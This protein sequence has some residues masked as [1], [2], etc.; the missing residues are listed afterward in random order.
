MTYIKWQ[1]RWCT[2]YMLLLCMNGWRR[3]HLCYLLICY[4]K[5]HKKVKPVL[6]KHAFSWSKC[7]SSVLGLNF[8]SH[9][10]SVLHNNDKKMM[11]NLPLSFWCK[12]IF[13]SISF[14]LFRPAKTGFSSLLK[15]FNNLVQ[16]ASHN[17]YGYVVCV[18]V[19]VLL[20]FKKKKDA[21][22]YLSNESVTISNVWLNQTA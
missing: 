11:L 20:F 18:F 3:A 19:F 8:Q 9:M 12:E 16:F 21:C 10:L 14:L 15:R 13:L 4:C 22:S 6:R 17:V 5:T 1:H 2:S 7:E